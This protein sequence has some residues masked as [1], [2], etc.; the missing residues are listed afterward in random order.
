MEVNEVKI[1]CMNLKDNRDTPKQNQDKELKF[2]LCRERSMI[3]IGWAVEGDVNSWEDYERKANALYRDN[4]AYTSAHNCLQ[5]MSAGDLVWTRNPVTHECY[6]VDITDETP[7]IYDSLKEFDICGYRSGT[8]YLVPEAKLIG[9]LS[10][11]N[12]SAEQTIDQIRSDGNRKAVIEATK[13]L[14]ADLK[15]G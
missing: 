3:A 6:L 8:Y 11:R 15:H 12:L 14:F 7:R 2:R 5:S 10:P 4:S 13:Q 9:D 1:W